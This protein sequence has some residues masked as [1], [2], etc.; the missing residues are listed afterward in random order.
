MSWMEREIRHNYQILYEHTTNSYEKKSNA[1]TNRT[2]VQDSRYHTEWCFHSNKT[3]KKMKQCKNRLQQNPVKLQIIFLPSQISCGHIMVPSSTRNRLWERVL[4]LV[5]VQIVRL[6]LLV[7]IHR[8]GLQL[9]CWSFIKLPLVKLDLNDCVSTEFDC[10]C[11]MNRH[12]QCIYYISGR[13]K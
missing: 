4:T 8:H 1:S 9:I 5:A 6:N 7:F 11:S 10:I 3:K 12:S 2:Y 13:A